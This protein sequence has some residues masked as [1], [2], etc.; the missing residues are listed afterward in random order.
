MEAKSMAQREFVVYRGQ[1]FWLQTTGR[2][3]QSG[4]KDDP[5][6]LLHRRVY[7]DNFGPIPEGHDVH[8]KDTDWRNNESWNLEAKIAFDH[9]REHMLERLSDPV[10]FAKNQEYL[11]R[12]RIAAAIWHG[13]PEG[14]KWHK[15]HGKETWLDRLPVEAICSKCGK[16]YWT[17]FPSR[18]RF[19]SSACMQAVA[20]RTY[21]TDT[22]ICAFCGKEFMANRHRK[23]ACCSTLCSNRKRASDGNL[24][25]NP[26]GA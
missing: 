25:S 10:A 21:F 12:A 13:S 22:R 7:V 17:Y 2:Y 3:F 5:E 16:Q 14:I 20:F 1:K 24:Q 9:D 8:H 4:R 6:R 11:E 26:T 19:C 23:T 15:K 18:S